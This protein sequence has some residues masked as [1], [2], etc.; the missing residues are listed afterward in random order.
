MEVNL[1][2]CRGGG[3]NESKDIFWNHIVLFCICKDGVFKLQD[4]YHCNVLLA[5]A[6]D[7][8][9]KS[10]YTLNIS[11]SN[12]SMDSMLNLKLCVNDGSNIFPI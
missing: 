7:F 4:A 3:T 8:E 9:S 5:K 6:L 10:L 2:F 11:A 1:I 12:V